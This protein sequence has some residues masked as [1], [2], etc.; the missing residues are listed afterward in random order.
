MIMTRFGPGEKR[1]NCFQSD[2]QPFVFSFSA[3]VG[4]LF[5]FKK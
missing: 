4:L 1:R 3:F 5:I 2:Q